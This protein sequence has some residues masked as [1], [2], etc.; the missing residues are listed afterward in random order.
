MDVRARPDKGTTV[1]KLL[2]RLDKLSA[3]GVTITGGL[4]ERVRAFECLEIQCKAREDRRVS[5]DVLYFGYGNKREVNAVLV[6]KLVDL[7]ETPQFRGRYLHRFLAMQEA[8]L[9]GRS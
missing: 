9:L 3:I 2:A 4:R 8:N 5:D 1:S 6:P 7:I